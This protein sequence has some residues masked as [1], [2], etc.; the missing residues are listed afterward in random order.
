ML[1]LDYLQM[2]I[3]ITVLIAIALWACKAPILLLYVKLFGVHR[4]LRYSC[5]LT[6]ALS[7]VLMIAA[8]APTF[9]W[10]RFGD[11]PL[12]AG[13]LNTCVHGTTLTGVITGFITT[14]ADV[15]ILLLP[16]PAIYELRLDSRRKYG[17]AVV[18]FS[19]FL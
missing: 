15:V 12:Q 9:A 1:T 7:G 16:M 13:V 4:W 5:Y 17:L 14:P 8:M 19:G 3:V 11:E 10:C 6:L 18:F 2:G